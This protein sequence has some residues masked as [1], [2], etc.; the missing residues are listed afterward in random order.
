M[1]RSDE[2]VPVVAV[3]PF[4]R[5]KPQKAV[6]ALHDSSDVITAQ[7]PR[8]VEFFDQVVWRFGYERGGPWILGNNQ[9]WEKHPNNEM[10]NGFIKRFSFKYTD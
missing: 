3:Q 4:M 5:T 7:P 6:R 10:T 8:Q 2:L 1:K 9:N